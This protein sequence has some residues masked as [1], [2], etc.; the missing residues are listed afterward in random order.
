MRLLPSELRVNPNVNFSQSEHSA[1]VLAQRLSLCR[2]ILKDLFSCVCSCCL[3]RLQP[4][5]PNFKLTFCYK[6]KA[7][8]PF[9]SSICNR[10]SAGLFQLY[11]TPSHSAFIT[12]YCANWGCFSN[13]LKDGQPADKVL[14]I[15]IFQHETQN[16]NHSHHKTKTN[17]N[18][19]TYGQFVLIHQKQTIDRQGIELGVSKGHRYFNQS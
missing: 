3:E 17:M 19:Q 18:W 2:S 16:N 11:L 8:C 13:K 7:A 4:W 6:Q 12:F 15:Y 1:R 9:K 10:P 5:V 14:T